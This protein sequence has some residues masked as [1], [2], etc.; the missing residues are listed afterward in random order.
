MGIYTIFLVIISIV[1]QIDEANVSKPRKEMAKE[2][3]GKMCV[4]YTNVDYLPIF[5]YSE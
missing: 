5:C 4:F 3:K 1:Y 2:R